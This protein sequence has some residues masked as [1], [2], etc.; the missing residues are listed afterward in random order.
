M[1]MKRFLQLVALL[2]LS[3]TFAFQPVGPSTIAR[4]SL[5]NGVGTCQHVG[6]SRRVLTITLKNGK[7]DDE[8]ESSGWNPFQALS[9]AFGSFDDVLDDFMFKRMGNGE[10]FYGKRKIDPSGRENTEGTYNGM[11]MSDKVKIDESRQRKEEYLE[12]RRRKFLEE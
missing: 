9:E 5:N 12:E 11:G 4:T 2:C 6:P 7:D 3:D 1:A 8:K 10:V